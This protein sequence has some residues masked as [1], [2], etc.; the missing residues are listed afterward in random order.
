MDVE[1]PKKRAI[2]FSQLKE[3][4]EYS[5]GDNSRRASPCPAMKPFEVKSVI[6]NSGHVFS[7][8]V[9]ITR[10]SILGHRYIPHNEK[11]V[12]LFSAEHSLLGPPPD[13]AAISSHPSTT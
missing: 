12:E 4:L 10:R 8:Q 2:K 11:V 1:T 3:V 5:K 6:K 9:P 7:G 13:D